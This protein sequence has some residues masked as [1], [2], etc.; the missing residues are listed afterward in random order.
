MGERLGQ[1]SLVEEAA[2][3]FEAMGASVALG[4]A[5]RALGSGS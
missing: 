3:V 5:R 4:I 2:A 1:S